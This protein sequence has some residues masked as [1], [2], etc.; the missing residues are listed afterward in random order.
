MHGSQKPYVAGRGFA[1]SRT[2]QQPYSGSA[3]PAEPEQ[4]MSPEEAWADT[5]AGLTTDFERRLA[6]H[7]REE[8]AFGRSEQQRS[9]WEHAHQRQA[10]GTGQYGFKG[11]YKSR[12]EL[13]G[14]PAYRNDWLQL[15]R[16]EVHEGIGPLGARDPIGS[17][18]QR[19]TGQ[20]TLANREAALEA[21]G[22]VLGML[23]PG[24]DGGDE[25]STSLTTEPSTLSGGPSSPF[26]R[27]G[28]LPK[29]SQFNG[30]SFE[31]F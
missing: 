28:P 16:P 5:H 11:F 18:V 1:P 20:Q 9:T 26:P 29:G 2:V 15:N 10:M 12:R 23:R 25:P 30:V 17:M 13:T 31:P 24:D 8:A 27:S 4:E 21:E 19:R 6:A 3:E 7:N 22:H 14:T